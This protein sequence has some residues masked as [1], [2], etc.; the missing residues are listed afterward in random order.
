[1]VFCFVVLAFD[2]GSCSS[3]TLGNSH[4]SRLRTHSGSTAAAVVVVLIAHATP[5][6]PRRTFQAPCAVSQESVTWRQQHCH[7][8]ESLELEYC[9]EYSTSPTVTHILVYQQAAF[10]SLAFIRQRRS[11]NFS[12]CKH[13]ASTTPFGQGVARSIFHN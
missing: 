6:A 11:W 5:G 8:E 9:S 7:M 13:L 4:S 3:S 10:S 12:S 2:A 1:M